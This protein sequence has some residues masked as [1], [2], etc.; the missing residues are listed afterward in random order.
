MSAAA[1]TDFPHAVASIIA[2]GDELVLGQKLDTNSQFIADRLV[3]HGLQV[4][5]HVT[6][7]DDQVALVEALRR[8]VANSQLV[9]VTGGLG[10]T[11]DDLTRPA[12]AELLG[13]R[14]VIDEDALRTLEGWFTSRGRTMPPGNRVQAMRPASA[15]MLT[16]EHGTAPALHAVYAGRCDIYCLPG[17][18][19]EM[20]PLLEREVVDHLRVEPA[21][22]CRTLALHTFGRGESD[23]AALLGDLMDR[24]RNP[25]V[26]TTA[27]LGVVSVRIRASGATADT[28]L[29]QAVADVRA[30]LGP[31]VLED[32][33]LAVEVVSRLRTARQ[34]VGTVES[35]TGGMLG[36]FITEVPGA[37]DVYAGGLIT[38]SNEQKVALACVPKPFF[39]TDGAV[40]RACAV[41]MAEGG[42]HRL[43]TDHALSITG[44]AGPNGG[45]PGKPVGT[46]WI[47]LAS[48]G[49]PTDA[50]RFLF[51]GSR[52]AIRTW[53]GVSALGMLR[54]RL[55]GAD[56][57]L[58][59]QQ[60]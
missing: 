55:I 44:I 39:D 57:R 20:I 26:G 28:L 14:L 5:E 52:S 16:N 21:L 4:R 7:P 34:S 25:L 37:S 50:R 3:C 38:Y 36:Q 56:M 51:R 33:H 49:A 32:E 22:A 27:S 9:I 8:A 11:A 42:R 15:R 47:A 29:A 24:T 60:E 35:C 46:V 58:L 53:S 30:R 10:P 17:P 6:V 59:N 1:S 48:S 19:R 54:L 23:V 18:P 45:T 40:S 43:Q 41:A 31:I 13:E 12:L 2:S